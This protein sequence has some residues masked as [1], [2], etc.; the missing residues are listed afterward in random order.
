MPAAALIRV[1]GRG[2]DLVLLHGWGM[3][4]GCWGEFA[5]RLSSRYRLHLVSLPG[6]GGTPDSDWSARG[7]V[8]ELIGKLPS[9]AWLGWSLGGTLALSAALAYPERVTSLVLL[10]VTPCFVA[11]AHWPYG[12]SASEF[13]RF[14][15]YCRDDPEVTTRRFRSR[16]ADGGP[17]PSAVMQLLEQTPV[18]GRQSLLGGLSVLGNTDLSAELAGLRTNALWVCAGQDRVVRPEAVNAAAA[19]HASGQLLMLEDA[20]HAPHLDHPQVLSDRVGA[21]L[22]EAAAA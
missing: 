5:D 21:W 9:A 14:E 10:A 22:A 11:R 17:D 20:C 1:H 4:I 15:G 13:R 6:H 16:V 7:L 18:A 19:S 12:V 2:P 8:E 3:S